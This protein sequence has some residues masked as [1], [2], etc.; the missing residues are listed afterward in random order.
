MDF[1]KFGEEK[2]NNLTIGKDVFRKLQTNFCRA[3]HVYCQCFGADFL[4]LTGAAGTAEQQEF[5]IKAFNGT[6]SV[7]LS[8]LIEDNSVESVVEDDMTLPYLKLSAVIVRE[9]GKVVAFWAVYGVIEEKLG[10]DVELP[11]GCYV[12]KEEDYYASIALLETVLKEYAIKRDLESHAIERAENE[13]NRMEELENELRFLSIM[14]N[15]HKE[16]RGDMSFAELAENIISQGASYLDV[17]YA[18]LL[19]RVRGLNQIAEVAHFWKNGINPLQSATEKTDIESYPFF[20]GKTYIF[21]SDSILPDAFEEYFNRH[22]IKAGIFMP[23]EIGGGPNMYLMIAVPGIPRKFS[24]SD[25][26][27]MSDM[28]KILQNTLVKKIRQNSLAGSFSALENLINKINSA[29]LVSD[30]DT[31]NMLYM[32]KAYKKLASESDINNGIRQLFAN[33][34]VIDDESHTEFFD[35]KSGKWFDIFSTSISWVDGRNTILSVINETT[36]KKTYLQQVE[37][38]ANNDFLTGLYNRMRF[39]KDLSVTMAKAEELGST[40]ALI[41]LDLDDFKSVTEGMGHQYGDELLKE[42][43]RALTMIDGIENS[44]YAMGA[45]Q[46]SIIVNHIN[47]PRLSDILL[48]IKRTFD[49]PW[50]LKNSEYY[51]YM[52]M[53]IA[54]FPVNGRTVEDIMKKAD[55]ALF[56]SKRHGRNGYEYYIEEMIQGGIR[57]SDLEKNILFAA[58]DN[59]SEFGVF[60]Q[61]IL[62]LDGTVS[63]A[64]ALVR[65]H[66]RELGFVAPD[67]FIPMAEYLR[68]MSPIGSYVLLQALRACKQWADSGRPEYKVHVN[69]SVSQLIES[70]ILDQI[71][72]AL[73]ETGLEP[74]KLVIEVTESLAINDIDRMKR[75]L[76]KIRD[77]GVFVALDDFGQ[78][79]SSLN[80][81]RK[82]PINMIKIDRSYIAGIAG[83]NFQQSFVKM[84]V[85]LANSMN[86]SVCAEGVEYAEDEMVVK[87]LRVDKMQGYLFDKPLSLEQFV[88][89]YV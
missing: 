58:K 12:V 2:E 38:K 30:P 46:F 68:L 33:H 36:E 50:F 7:R 45:E 44:C 71:E 4:P 72:K 49:R 55:I 37:K 42:I 76:G 75:I 41:Y 80:Y 31:Y 48:K 60:F 56:E 27:F 63:G 17:P 88:K 54:L 62:N 85:E 20:T 61:P 1:G 57:R 73:K 39:E 29:I 87:A 10:E 43:S 70:D 81:I 64:E 79:Y 65:W 82:M 22:G 3:N 24:I 67:S 6:P 52:N 15:I 18:V 89:R 40:G 5:F 8:P 84:V 32:N 47:Y 19:Q 9:L 13:S 66:S 23:I 74:E 83:D 69:L 59:F 11:Q 53:G 16:N 26:Q 86:L 14:N 25:I 35:A 21:S 28:K 78:G 51:C 77:I 34:M